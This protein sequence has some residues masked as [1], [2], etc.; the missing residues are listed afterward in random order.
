MDSATIVITTKDR[1]ELFAKALQSVAAQSVECEIIVIDD[2]PAKIDVAGICE[3]AP[4]PVQYVRNATPRG[5]IAA[6]NQA[7]AMATG[8]F[9]FTLDDDAV[10]ASPDLV[11][12]VC[13]E[14]RFPE[15]GAV[16]IPLTD[17]YPDGRVKQ[18]L[19]RL[20]RADEFFCTP[21][22]AGGANALRRCVIEQLG[23]YS[24]DGRQ[25][26]EQDFALRMLDL[27]YLVKVA[28][29][30]MID[31]YPQHAGGRPPGLYRMNVRANVMMAGRIVPLPHALTYSLGNWL[32]HTRIAG[33]GAE[34][35]DP[36][37]GLVQG[38]FG[39]LRAWRSRQPV[40]R[41]TY[42]TFRKW[43][44][45]WLAD[46]EIYGQVARRHGRELRR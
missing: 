37:I 24:G 36:H 32:S 3:D 45:L 18:R 40:S 10:F 28:N 43:V 42:V 22:F 20:P 15:V 35:L 11:Q 7:F 25:G 2:G 23:G 29:D 34:S 21:Q 44:R 26:E 14:F 41:S 8:E 30:C 39:C 27:G 31:H 6:R 12:R 46:R 17:H 13:N 9:V 1:P 16:G 38:M 19:P 4:C 33:L 5:I